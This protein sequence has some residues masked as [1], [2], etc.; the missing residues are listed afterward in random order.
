MTTPLHAQQEAALMLG[1]KPSLFAVN[2][3]YFAVE[4]AVLE[5]ASGESVVYLKRRFVPPAERLALLQEHV[6]AQGERLDTIAAK[7]LGDPEH[8]LH[9]WVEENRH[10]RHIA[11]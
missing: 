8:T 7:Y 6:V 3:R 10:T 9:E 5:S 11:V 4:T 2:S 1:L